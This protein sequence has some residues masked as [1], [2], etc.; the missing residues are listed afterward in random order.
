MGR[1][2]V[3]SRG[4]IYNRTRK[5]IHAVFENRLD[6]LDNERKKLDRWARGS[7]DSD[8]VP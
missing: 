3:A 2:F 4:R 1:F 8:D 5:L 7:E 6:I